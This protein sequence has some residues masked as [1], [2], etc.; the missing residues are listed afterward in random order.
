M[1]IPTFE[2]DYLFTW[3][4][5]NRFEAVYFGKRLKKLYR[6]SIFYSFTFSFCKTEEKR[7]ITIYLVKGQLEDLFC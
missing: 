5:K 3:V 7:C 4:V 2:N 1:K 6:V